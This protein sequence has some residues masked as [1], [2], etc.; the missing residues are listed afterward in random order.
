MN[1]LLRLIGTGILIILGIRIVNW[2]LSPVLPLLTVMFV[3]VLILHI[4][5]S[6]F[7]HGL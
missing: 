5:T 2:L 6:G 1:K 7:K 4:A 3:T